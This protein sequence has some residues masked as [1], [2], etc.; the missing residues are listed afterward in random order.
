M[1]IP[2]LYGGLLLVMDN[3]ASDEIA[4][5]VGVMV[6]AILV[7]YALGTGIGFWARRGRPR[8]IARTLQRWGARRF[9]DWYVRHLEVALGKPVVAV[10][11]ERLIRD[12]V[13]DPKNTLDD[14]A[15]RELERYFESRMSR[16]R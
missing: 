15:L 10:A 13:R 12:I 8:L 5:T 16:S 6:A 11:R 2:K 14:E 9:S 1:L 3:F 7:A 4:A